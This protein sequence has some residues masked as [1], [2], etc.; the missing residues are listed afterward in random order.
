M[1]N[2][3]NVSAAAAA[4]VSVVTLER[5]T[6]PELNRLRAE[7]GVLAGLCDSDR[8]A[9]ASIQSAAFTAWDSIKLIEREIG[10]L[11]TL[12]SGA[13]ATAKSLQSSVADS[14]PQR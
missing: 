6:L 13:L 7:L 1:I 10:R 8:P 4:L 3:Q 9:E 2:Q 12:A 14:L 11:G 5:A